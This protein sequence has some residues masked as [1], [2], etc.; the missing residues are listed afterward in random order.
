WQQL[1]LLLWKNF[2]LRKRHPIRTIIEVLWPIFLFAILVAIRKTQPIDTKGECHYPGRAMPSAGIYPWFKSMFC[3]LENPCF[4]KEVPSEVPGQINSPGNANSAWM[5]NAVSSILMLLQ[6]NTSITQNQNQ[7]IKDLQAVQNFTAQLPF[8]STR[9]STVIQ[10]STAYTEFVT[11]NLSIPYDVVKALLNSTVSPAQVMLQTIFQLPS[12]SQLNIT[13]VS[14]ELCNLTDYQL[15][16]LGNYTTS[17][18]ETSSQTGISFN[19]SSA[20][21]N[22]ALK[23]LSG[24]SSELQSISGPITNLLSTQQFST[25]FLGGNFSFNVRSITFPEHLYSTFTEFCGHSD[26]KTKVSQLFTNGNQDFTSKIALLALPLSRDGFNSTVFCQNLTAI[27]ESNNQFKLLWDVLK[28]L[29]LGKIPYSPDTPLVRSIIKRANATFETIAIVKEFGQMWQSTNGPALHNFLENGSTVHTLSTLL[30]IS[31]SNLEQVRTF[32]SNDYNATDGVITWKDLYYQ[33]NSGILFITNVLGCFELNKFEGYQSEQR[34]VDASLSRTKNKTLWGAIVFM[35]PTENSEVLPKIVKYK[36]RQDAGS[37]TKTTSIQSFSWEPDAEADYTSN[38]MAYYNGG[39]LFL[40]DMVEQAIIEGVVPEPFVGRYMQEF[41]YPCYTYDEFLEY[42]SALLSLLMTLAWIY[43]VCIIIKNIVYEKEQRLKEVM[44]MMGLSN[45]VHWVAWFINSFSLMFLSILLLILVLKVGDVT[46]YSNMFIVLIWLCCFAIA[47]ISQCFLIS[48]FFSRANLAAACGGIIYFLMYIPYNMTYAWQDEMTIST[49]LVA[50]LLST[51]AFGY[52][53]GYISQYE[54]SG[55]GI[56]FSNWNTSPDP[57]DHMNFLLSMLM[58]LVDAAIY[59]ILTWYIEAVFP[60]QYGVP[61]PWNFFLQR[62]YWCGSTDDLRSNESYSAYNQD[63]PSIKLETEPSHLKLGVSMHNLSKVY[64]NGKVA[65]DGLSLNFYEN[66]ITAF[67][68]HNGAGKTTT[69]SML[70]GLFPPSGGTAS[71]YKKD[72]QTDMDSI[73]HELGF[74]PQHN[75][76]FG[77]LTVLEHLQLYAGLKGSSSGKTQS[78]SETNN[79]LQDV[80]LPHKKHEMTRH[81]SGGMKRKLSVAIAF[82]GGSKCVVLDEPTAGV[83]PYAR[84][85]IWDLLLHYKQNRTIVLSTHHMDEADLLGDRIA[86]IS[87]GKLKC[88]GSSLFLKSCFGVGYYLTLQM[89]DGFESS[90]SSSKQS[91]STLEG[92]STVSTPSTSKETS[93]LDKKSSILA[94]MVTDTISG[95]KLYED[96]GREITFVLPYSAQTDGS[97]AKLFEKLNNANANYGLTDTSLEEIFLNVAEHSKDDGKEENTKC[98]LLFNN[99]FISGLLCGF[100]E[101]QTSEMIDHSISDDVSM[102]DTS[103]GIG[104]YKVEGNKLIRQQF[105]S[106]FVKR[107]HHARRN[108]KGI[109][110]QVIVPAA[111]VALALTFALI[112]PQTKEYPSLELQPWMYGDTNTFFSNDN[113]SSNITSS[114]SNALINDPSIGMRCVKDYSVY[115]YDK[116]FLTC[117]AIDSTKRALSQNVTSNETIECSCTDKQTR[118]LLAECPVGTGGAPTPRIITRTS[119]PMYNMTQRNLSDWLVKTY[120]D[121]PCS[122]LWV[123]QYRF[124]GLSFG[125]QYYNTIGSMLTPLLQFSQS[126]SNFTLNINPNSSNNIQSVVQRLVRTDNSKVWFDNSGWHSMPTWLNIM[127]NAALR[128]SLPPSA[129]PTEYGIAAFNHPLNFTETEVDLAAFTQSA[130]DTIISISVIFA[131]AFV[132]ASF[133]LFLIEEK[134]SKAKHLQ[135]V[136]GVNQFIYWIANFTWD[137]LNYSIPAIIVIIIF[138]CFQTDAYVS[139]ANLPC[140]VCLLFLYGF[141]ITPM[142][143]PA[144]FYFEVPSTAY[145]VL[146]CINLFI[147]IN[148]SIATF[149]LE[150]LDD[151]NLTEVNNALKIIF[152]AFPQYCLGR[153][154]IDMAINQAYADAYA[155]FGINSFKNPF[156]YDLV[157]R[158]LLAMAIEGV[159]FFIL[160]VLIQYRFFIKHNKIEDLSKIPRRTG[161]EDD[162]VTAEKKRL[163]EE[164][165]ITDILQIKNLTKVYKKLGSKKR[166]LAVDR[167]SIGVPRGEC[168]GLLGVNG[169]GKTTTFKM[170]TGDI[171][172]TAGDATICHQSILDNIREVQQN[173]GYCP[174]FEALNQLLTGREHLEFYA[175]LRGVPPEDIDRVAQWGIMKFGLKMYADKSAGTYSGGNKRKLSA[176]IAFIGCPPV[177][178]LDEPTAGMDPLSRRFLWSRISEVVSNGRCIVLTS[179]SM[180]ECEALCSRLAIMVNGSFKCIGSPQHL[181][182]RYGEGY[183]ITVKVSDGT[184]NLENVQA[185]IQEAFP[186]CVVK[187]SHSSMIMY[188]VPLE[189]MN[190]SFLFDEMERNKSRLS[191]EDYS[192]NQTTL[193][194]VFVS[195]AK[196]QTDGFEHEY[197]LPCAETVTEIDEGQDSVVLQELTNNYS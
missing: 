171:A 160:T 119:N 20:G 74:C 27:L 103:Q 130:T 122:G 188:Q 131:L 30:N 163:L 65:V 194:E 50:C 82:V 197:G 158:N 193:D 52:G 67:L 68:G 141:A 127:N 14:N 110:A 117:N 113:S 44:K 147:G 118:V 13:A 9:F 178:F 175:K 144:S 23:R 57:S 24:Y 174:Q 36:I 12:T 164:G 46:P 138:L 47:T 81:L 31:V 83:D 62:S 170:L 154:L 10:N 77:D 179:H 176:A 16:L 98:W 6:Q 106:L 125:A 58:M 7:I 90:F 135:F 45:G 124:G 183:T 191:I 109:V 26:T 105:L 112:I 39:F 96:N 121:Y 196:L 185:F 37:V 133:V 173:T 56:Q 51:V 93:I 92:Q 75:V 19:Q 86:I 17:S 187:E 60:G 137:M 70:T 146:T 114:A 148:T 61:R 161:M 69:M 169:A 165:D 78:E 134:V 150:L 168:F 177:V 104:S 94:Q 8:N 162:D 120:I 15:T 166:L 66:Q 129:D 101:D 38:K 159:V 152:L 99:N 149:I 89:K 182:N 139:A 189:D 107:F 1:R 71:I 73:R 180:E 2:I 142:M 95:V 41:P 116:K 140:L 155:S 184:E 34:L 33:L 88:C 49:K 59:L 84:R 53:A 128:S 190:L 64:G 132:P 42:L 85:G 145:V 111:F 143:Y 40:Q 21:L 55:D 126:N 100:H 102:D 63:D 115:N 18:L 91:L 192:V 181:K 186:N 3:D 87:H 54:M 76:L 32:L 5:G 4:S 97:Y 195:F 172:P 156:D 136:S 48:C 80:G 35:N 29:L 22:E 25:G 72:I 28:P 123:V 157:G 153:A 108:T 79:M 43:S 167:M 151:P 11:N